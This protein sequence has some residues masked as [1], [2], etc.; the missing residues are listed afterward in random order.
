MVSKDQITKMT[1]AVHSLS[2]QFSWF[3]HL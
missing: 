1:Q 3:R 2:L